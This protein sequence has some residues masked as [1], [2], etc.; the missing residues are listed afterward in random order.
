MTE[1]PLTTISL[2]RHIST[3]ITTVTDPRSADTATCVLTAELVMTARYTI[4]SKNSLNNYNQCIE[5][6]TRILA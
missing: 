1:E 2:I 4:T 5:R 3:V 6:L